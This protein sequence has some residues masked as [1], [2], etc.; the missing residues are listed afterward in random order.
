MRTIVGTGGCTGVIAANSNAFGRGSDWLSK[1]G[2]IAL[3]KLL[4]DYWHRHGYPA[5]RFWAEPIEERFSKIG[6]Y[7]IHKIAC[8]LMNGLPPSYR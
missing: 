4:Q 7:E 6:T 1:R 2:A 8:N 3:A 5:A